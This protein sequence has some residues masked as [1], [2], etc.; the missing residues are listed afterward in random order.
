M[1]PH[2]ILLTIL[3]LYSCNQV[4]AIKAV[5]TES[6]PLSIELRD[7][8]FITEGCFDIGA[9]TLVVNDQ[10]GQLPHLCRLTVYYRDNQF[11]TSMGGRYPTIFFLFKDIYPND[12]PDHF[13]FE[14]NFQLEFLTDEACGDEYDLLKFYTGTWEEKHAFL[15]AVLH[16]SAK[17]CWTEGTFQFSIAT[18]FSITCP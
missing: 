16:P 3:L 2:S 4:P 12:N 13:I 14:S 18:N 6:S 9:E 11:I 1:K 10:A 15:A 8:Y 17:D 7:G 5:E